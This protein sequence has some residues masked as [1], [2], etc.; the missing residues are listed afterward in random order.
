VFDI[1]RFREICMSSS[2]AVELSWPIIEGKMLPLDHGYALYGSLCYALPQMHGDGRLWQVLP[3]R[4]ELAG[5]MLR[6]TMQS[7]LRIRAPLADVDELLF[8]SGSRL[9]VDYSIVRL[10]DATIK[11]LRPAPSLQSRIVI[12][13]SSGIERA[14][15]ESF[16]PSF[17]KQ[18]DQLTEDTGTIKTVMGK[19]RA[20]RVSGYRVIG[21]QMFVHGLSA[22]DSVRVQSIGIGAK[23][24]MGCGSFVSARIFT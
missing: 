5:P 21:W 2:D 14:E 17:L 23:R 18:L 11:P 8:L 6:L 22:T 7:E 1:A 10:G 12:I 3:V 19:R 24:K 9:E 15:E 13:K 4:G 16:L 20:I